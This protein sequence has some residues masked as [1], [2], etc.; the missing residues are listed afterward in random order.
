LAKNCLAC[1][2]ILTRKEKESKDYFNLRNYCDRKCYFKYRTG[3]NHPNY[4]N[5]VGP[6]TKFNCLNCNKTKTRTRQKQKY[7]ST[8]CQMEYEY[9]NGI[10]D[11]NTITAAANKAVIKRS[12]EKFKTNPAFMLN[13][14]GYMIIYVPQVGWVRHHRY[15]WEKEHGKI[16]VG[17]EIHYIDSNKLNNDLDNLQCLSKSDHLKLHA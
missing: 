4:K 13:D 11:K 2:K 8:K 7:C 10:R 1:N 16:P 14:A 15:L 17:Y 12:V 3:K 9:K 5:G 6:G